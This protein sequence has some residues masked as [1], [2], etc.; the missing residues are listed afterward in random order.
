MHTNP[1]ILYLG[2]YLRKQD[3]IHRIVYD[4]EYHKFPPV[5]KQLNSLQYNNRCHVTIKIKDVYIKQR[6]LTMTSI[7]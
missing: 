7:K 3:V 4:R 6:C 5:D 2:L 1:I